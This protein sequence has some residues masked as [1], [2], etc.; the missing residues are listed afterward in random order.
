M[1]GGEFFSCVLRRERG[2][3]RGEN[4]VLVKEVKSTLGLLPSF[5]PSWWGCERS[6]HNNRFLSVKCK[7]YTG[8]LLVGYEPISNVLLLVDARLR[9][10]KNTYILKKKE[11]NKI[12][13]GNWNGAVVRASASYRAGLGSLLRPDVTCGPCTPSGLFPVFLHPQ[14]W[15][16]KF[17]SGFYPNS[18]SFNKI[19]YR[20]VL[21]ITFH[22]L[23]LDSQLR[24][25]RRTTS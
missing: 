11:L 23:Y 5:T 8:V 20:L 2:R 24:I 21:F 18:D 4:W 3:G 15:H 16:A 17:Y 12:F 10:G 14:N 19:T 9:Q 1:D 7:Q 13:K 25:I 22:F 6:W